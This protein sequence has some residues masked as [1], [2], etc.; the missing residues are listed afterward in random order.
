MAESRGNSSQTGSNGKLANENGKEW[1]ITSETHLLSSHMTWGGFT[2]GGG[3]EGTVN[4]GGTIQLTPQ[5]R[6]I[7][8]RKKRPLRL[9]GEGWSG[10]N[11]NRC[12]NVLS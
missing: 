3:E 11:M 12:R 5:T 1:G 6:A 10:K 7:K 4:S 8:K 9:F 2:E